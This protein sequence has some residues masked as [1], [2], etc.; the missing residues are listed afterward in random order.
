MWYGDRLVGIEFFGSVVPLRDFTYSYQAD[1]KTKKIIA[2]VPDSILAQVKREQTGGFYKS[3][4]GYNKIGDTQKEKTG[5][6][7]HVVNVPSNL[8]RGRVAN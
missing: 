1:Y 2:S 5:P 6:T 8:S 4:D 3:P 7:H